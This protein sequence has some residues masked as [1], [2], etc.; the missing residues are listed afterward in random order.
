MALVAWVQR[1]DGRDGT[2]LALN[3]VTDK[4]RAEEHSF[5]RSCT[6]YRTRDPEEGP[7]LRRDKGI[8]YEIIHGCLFSRPA[9][10]IC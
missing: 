7:A 2:C 3:T 10:R 9:Y 5:R 4:D 8:R 1:M 6:A